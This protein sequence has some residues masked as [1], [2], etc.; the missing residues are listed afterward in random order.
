MIGGIRAQVIKD[1][2]LRWKSGPGHDPVMKNI[3]APT[4]AESR[5][6]TAVR[7]QHRAS[8]D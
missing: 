5:A 2:R 8:L 7:E 1:I 3:S 6:I 4:S